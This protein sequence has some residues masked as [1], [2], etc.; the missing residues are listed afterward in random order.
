MYILNMLMYILKPNLGRLL[1]KLFGNGTIFPPKASHNTGV[2][3]ETELKNA[4]LLPKNKGG[5]LFDLVN[6][7]RLIFKSS[8][9]NLNQKLNLREKSL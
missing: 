3:W 4:A 7:A 6:S 8:K 1:S 9:K 2:S 5:G